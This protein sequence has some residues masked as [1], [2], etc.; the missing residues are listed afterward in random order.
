VIV[1]HGD[2]D[3]CEDRRDDEQH[4]YADHEPTPR[5]SRCLHVESRQRGTSWARRLL[6]GGHSRGAPTKLVNADADEH[7]M[8]VGELREHALD[9][10]MRETKER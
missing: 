6:R 9:A 10:F 3:R 7:G 2:N 5:F 8:L 1:E 4:H